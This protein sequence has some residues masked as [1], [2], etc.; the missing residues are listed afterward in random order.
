M[1]S[2]HLRDVVICVNQHSVSLKYRQRIWPEPDLGRTGRCVLEK[3][4]FSRKGELRPV[5]W[6]CDSLPINWKTISTNGKLKNNTASDLSKNYRLL[7]HF[8]GLISLSPKDYILLLNLL[9]SASAFLYI[10]ISRPEAGLPL[11]TYKSYTVYRMLTCTFFT[12]G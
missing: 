9:T 6:G 2:D 7:R 12:L 5:K 4:L 11:W 10:S 3:S 8:L 1:L